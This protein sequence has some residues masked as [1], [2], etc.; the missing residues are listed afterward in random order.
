MQTCIYLENMQKDK[1]NVMPF[2]M[3]FMIKLIHYFEL[4]CSST[5]AHTLTRPHRKIEHVN[6]LRKYAKEHVCFTFSNGTHCK[7]ITLSTH[8]DICMSNIINSKIRHIY[9]CPYK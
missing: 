9:Q 3:G 8:R 1:K 5:H 6:L 7:V 4:L 2:L